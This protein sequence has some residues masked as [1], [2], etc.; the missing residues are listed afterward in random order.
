MP[1]STSGRRLVAEVFFSQSVPPFA[2]DVWGSVKQ[3][4]DRTVIRT[5]PTGKI[6][7]TQPAGRL[8]LPDWSVATTCLPTAPQ[9]LLGIGLRAAR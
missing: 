7:I 9:L 4:P 2:E 8:F 1:A 5:T 3:L 6:Y